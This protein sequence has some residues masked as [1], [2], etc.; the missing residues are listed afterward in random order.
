MVNNQ[1]QS[2]KKYAHIQD[3]IFFDHFKKKQN[4]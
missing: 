1:F 2:A 3:E 4:R